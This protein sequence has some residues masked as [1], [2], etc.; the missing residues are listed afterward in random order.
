MGSS[1]LPTVVPEAE[2]SVGTAAAAEQIPPR[3][4]RRNDT[5]KPIGAT[6]RQYGPALSSS[7]VEGHEFCYC[8]HHET[9]Q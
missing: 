2:E 6:G 8:P 4:A 3:V 1:S 9:I 7:V 5:P